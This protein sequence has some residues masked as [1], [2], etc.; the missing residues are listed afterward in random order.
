MLQRKVQPDGFTLLEV[1]LAMGLAFFLMIALYQSIAL[2]SKYNDVASAE[3]KEARV[4]RAVLLRISA[5]L[6]AVKQ[7]S[8]DTTVRPAMELTREEGMEPAPA[9][10]SPPIDSPPPPMEA[11]LEPSTLFPGPLT[12]NASRAPQARSLLSLLADQEL[13]SGDLNAPEPPVEVVEDE[14]ILRPER[15]GL[16]GTSNRLLLMVSRWGQRDS[17]VERYREE[18]S[19]GGEI[20]AAP[21]ADSLERGKREPTDVREV[22]Y[23]MRP[24][25]AAW[26][27]SEEVSASEE[28]E[29]PPRHLGLIR[30]EILYPFTAEAQLEAKRQLELHLDMNKSEDED[31]DPLKSTETEVSESEVPPEEM[32][33]TRVHGEAITAIRFRYHDGVEWLSGWDRDDELPLAVEIALSFDPR[34][35]DEETL[36]GIPEVAEE[37]KEE[38]VFP[39][40]LVVR[41]SGSRRPLPKL[42][43]ENEEG[44]EPN[45]SSGGTTEALP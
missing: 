7:P 45:N 8:P 34:A 18:K 24:N 32:V 12:T 20:S 27:Q 31:S 38:P 35:E 1:I 9:D 6:R 28:E 14:P 19:G 13:A 11:A 4:A 25:R 42:S 40:R 29:E 5:D 37:E 36:T 23:L 33:A 3:M 26:E 39:Y 17:V 43:P 21:S 44:Q 10:S 15:F 41:L 22:F 16:L 30:Q 2:Q